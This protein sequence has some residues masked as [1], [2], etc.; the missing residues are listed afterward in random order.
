MGFINPLLYS[1]P[2][3]LRDVVVGDNKVGSGN[4]GYSAAKGWDA[5]TALGSP[6][7]AKLLAVLGG[8]RQS[9]ADVDQAGVLGF[10]KMPRPV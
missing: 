3:A 8:S 9:A 7:G 6:D 10:D 2:S 1:N 5:C 4:I